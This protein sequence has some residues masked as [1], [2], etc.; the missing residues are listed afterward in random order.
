MGNNSES[1]QTV[2]WVVDDV[3]L[4]TSEVAINIINRIYLNEG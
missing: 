4:N 1:K 2:Y 3:I